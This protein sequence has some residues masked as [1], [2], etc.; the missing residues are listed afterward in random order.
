MDPYAALVTHER[1]ALDVGLLQVPIHQLVDRR[2][3]V[4]GA[5]RWSTWA[6]RRVRA[7]SASAAAL[8]PGGIVSVSLIFLPVIGSMPAYT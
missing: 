8:G 5:R 7:F 4:R 1:G 2:A 6:R 3:R